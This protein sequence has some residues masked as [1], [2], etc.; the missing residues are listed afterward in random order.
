LSQS[1]S[2]SYVDEFTPLY[3]TLRGAVAAQRF[4]LET[5]AGKFREAQLTC[6]KMERTRKSALLLCASEIAARPFS[7]R[8]PR[9]RA[10]RA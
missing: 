3:H 6:D 10:A 1:P 7:L 4:V 2:L 9:V 5:A 8:F